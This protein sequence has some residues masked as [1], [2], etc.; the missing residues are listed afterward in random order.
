MSKRNLQED[1]TAQGVIVYHRTGS[2]DENYNLVLPVDGFRPENNTFY[3]KG[4]YTSLSLQQM[5]TPAMQ[6]K[7]GPLLV[8]SK[9]TTV[10]GFLSFLPDATKIIHRKDMTI[11]EQVAKIMGTSIQAVQADPVI[12]QELQLLE[13]VARTEN[14]KSAGQGLRLLAPKIFSKLK[15]VITNDPELGPSVIIYNPNTVIPVRYKVGNDGEWRNA[16]GNLDFYKKVKDFYQQ[17][18]QSYGDK[19]KSNSPQTQSL[20]AEE[21]V[22]YVQLLARTK[23]K[24]S[25]VMMHLINQDQN[26]KKAFY[27]PAQTSPKPNTAVPA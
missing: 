10:Q 15:G 9:V 4:I 26:L 25:D 16:G 19:N 23:S 12:S 20:P 14:S 3:G 2:H 22:N 6:D 7:Y 13:E 17:K 27:G 21:I 8:E 11:A 1:I 24:P 5:E 18:Q